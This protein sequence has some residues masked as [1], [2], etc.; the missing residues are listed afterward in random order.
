MAQTEMNT[1]QLVAMYVKLRDAKA[2]AVAA[3]KQKIAKADEAMGKLEA[4]LLKNL[5]ATGAESIRT[6][7][8]TAF[9]AVKTS[10][11]V[12]DWDAMLA[13]ILEHGLYNM[14]ERRVS[15]KAV[16][17]FKDENDDLPPGVSWREEL[18][19]QVRRT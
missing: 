19:I 12:A 10:A 17:E 7:S 5:D 11:T 16:E 18:T 6:Q 15:K 4:Q 2:T 14:L 1:E 13:Y 8:G 9:K 3:F